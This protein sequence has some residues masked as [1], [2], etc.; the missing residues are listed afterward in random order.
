[1]Y[2]HWSETFLKELTVLLLNMFNTT[3]RIIRN[4]PIHTLLQY[5]A[6]KTKTETICRY[7]FINPPG[8][9]NKK[10]GQHIVKWG[11]RP[12][13]KLPPPHIM[14]FSLVLKQHVI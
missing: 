10:K 8:H 1:M 9:F 6:A 2:V 5:C 4:I 14:V 13:Y 12:R 11:I 3:K 7:Y